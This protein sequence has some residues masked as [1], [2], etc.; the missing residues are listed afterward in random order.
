MQH[1]NSP[2]GGVYASIG[3]FFIAFG[4]PSLIDIRVKEL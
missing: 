3:T 4:R 1:H 2:L